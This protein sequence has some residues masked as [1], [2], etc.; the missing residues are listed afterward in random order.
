VRPARL[1]LLVPDSAEIVAGGAVSLVTGLEGSGDRRSY[2]WLVRGADPGE[3]GVRVETDH[4]GSDR[5]V[6]EVK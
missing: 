6:P 1:E 2:R 4:A 3:V 5:R